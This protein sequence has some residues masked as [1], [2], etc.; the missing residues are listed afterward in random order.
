MEKL[1]SDGFID[2]Y[3]AR[4]VAKGYK[5]QKNID[6]FDTFAPVTKISSIRVL[7]ALASIYNLVIHQMDVKTTFLNG[8]LEEE[9]YMDK[10]E[11]Y[12]VEGKERKDMGIA[13]VI[14]GIKITRDSDGICLSQTNRGFP[15]C[16]RQLLSSMG[17]NCLLQNRYLHHK[18]ESRER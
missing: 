11:G 17:K 3:K 7:I 1:K 8:E 2:K 14:H 6:Y 9:I 4:L 5:Q 13:N 15:W 16:A 18:S 12:V 10:L